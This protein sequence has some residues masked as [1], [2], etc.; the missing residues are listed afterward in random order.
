MTRLVL[1]NP[2]TS[3]ATTATMLEIARSAAPAGVEL[4]GA[5]A[6]SG[7]SLITDESQLATAAEAVLDLLRNLAPADG[8]IIAA[9]GDPA[10]AAAR[11]LLACQVTGIAEAGMAEA[12]AGGRPFA[13][14]TT[15]PRLAASITAVAERYGHGAIFRRVH[16]T[17]GEPETLMANLAALE[18][19]LADACHAAMRDGAEAVVIGGGP[20]ALAARAIAPRLPLPVIEP[21]PAAVR[22]A[23]ARAKGRISP[24]G[25]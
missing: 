22:L 2:N 25:F 15:T 12:A 23:A 24:T 21:V 3:A 8:V 11:A 7:A 6:A 9:F 1:V 14:A 10:L 13:V 5:M 17:P 16:L 19:A 4:T 20:L 18:A